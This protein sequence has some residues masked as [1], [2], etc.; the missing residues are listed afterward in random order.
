MTRQY[1]SHEYIENG[2]SRYASQTSR[3]T[4]QGR[5]YGQGSSLGS[6]GVR[7]NTSSL[8]NANTRRTGQIHSNEYINELNNWQS[9]GASQF[10]IESGR[11]GR[12]S[13][14]THV[15]STTSRG[16]NQKKEKANRGRF[17]LTSMMIGIVMFF[18]CF[19][20]GVVVGPNLPI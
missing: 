10:Q 16:R 19:M 6:Q 17:F 18:V 2:R 14:Q 1:Q 15:A 12:S 4:T 9:E 5:T 8:S 11:S 3:R 7:R 13:Q 20:V